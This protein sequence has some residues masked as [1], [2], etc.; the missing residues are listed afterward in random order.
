MSDILPVVVGG[1]LALVGAMLGTILT[2]VNSHLERRQRRGEVLR[3][4]Y[5]ELADL[6]DETIGWFPTL[7]LCDTMQSLVTAHPPKAVRSLASLAMV[8]FPELVK[9]AK[10]YSNAVVTYYQWMAN[11]VSLDG[12]NSLGELACRIPEYQVLLNATEECRRDLEEAIENHASKYT[13]S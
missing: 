1:G 2:F 9:P 5:E 6:V 4:K 13:A 8:Y 12:A 10:D 7:D 3:Q 11:S